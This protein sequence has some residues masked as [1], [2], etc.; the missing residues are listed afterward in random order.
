[1]KNWYWLPAILAASLLALNA[2]GGGGGGGG[3]GGG[4][5]DDDD[6]VAPNDDDVTDDDDDITD[7][8]DDLP[9]LSEDKTRELATNQARDIVYSETRD[10]LAGADTELVRGLV[11]QSVRGRIAKGHAD[12]ARA[13]RVSQ[14]VTGDLPECAYYEDSATDCCTADNLCDY[15]NDGVCDCDGQ[16]AW[17]AEDC[18]DHVS[19]CSEGDPCGYAG[20]GVCDCEGTQAW[21]A[22]D[23]TGFLDCCDP[24]DPC[25]WAADGICDCDGTQ[26]WDVDDC[27][28]FESDSDYFYLE[29]DGECSVDGVVYSGAI[30]YDYYVESS[31]DSSYEYFWVDYVDYSEGGNS[32]SGSFY[33]EASVDYGSAVITNCYYDYSSP[34]IGYLDGCFY[35]ERYEDSDYLSGY[36]YINDNYQENDD[37][38]SY[39][40]DSYTEEGW[41]DITIRTSGVRDEV[42]FAASYRHNETDNGDGTSWV[43]GHGTMLDPDVGV[44]LT[45]EYDYLLDPETCGET[46]SEGTVVFRN[47][48]TVLST[49][50]YN[51]DEIGVETPAA[52]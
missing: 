11:P 15:A 23:C 35:Q 5:D 45:V 14:A 3:S 34:E 48:E 40:E 9:L 37:I 10:S 22:D 39:Y 4:N 46:P 29:F 12:N 25:G 27:T 21:D 44:V 6:D 13:R 2:C 26:D 49:A 38:V 17:D 30:T 8:D 50:T 41:L 18:V 31:K 1:M 33:Y 43:Q 7:D 32:Y 52:Q 28:G 24:T 16:Q 19:C 51:C 20:D 36:S 42:P 47:T